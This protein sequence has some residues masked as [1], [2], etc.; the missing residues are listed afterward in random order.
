MAVR[1][2][3]SSLS[4]GRSC[5]ACFFA[6]HIPFCLKYHREKSFICIIPVSEKTCI[7]LS[8]NIGLDSGLRHFKPQ[9][10]AAVTISAVFG[11]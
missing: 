7:Y 6:L 10:R 5:L 11:F 1:L 3:I 2:S 9:Q 4:L 8:S